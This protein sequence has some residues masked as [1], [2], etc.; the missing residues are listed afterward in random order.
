MLVKAGLI[1]ESDR[2]Y[3]QR[4]IEELFIV[5]SDRAFV[6]KTE[7]IFGDALNRR[8]RIAILSIARDNVQYL[9]K[10]PEK[11]DPKQ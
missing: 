6:E 11:T 1:E 3:V 7:F 2:R 8:V 4:L 9:A 10:L 5:P